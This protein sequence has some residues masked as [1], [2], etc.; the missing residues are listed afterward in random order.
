MGQMKRVFLMCFIWVIYAYACVAQSD[1]DIRAIVSAAGVSGLEDLDEY[2]IE[3]Y[4]ALLS[5]PVRIN[6]E[7]P[8]RLVSSGLLSAFQSASLLDYRERHGDILSLAELSS[9]DGF[10]SDVVDALAP[11]IS[12]DSAGGIL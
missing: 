10:T 5:S 4:W 1:E 11:F 2:D 8:D 7:G 12:M 3:L 6:V 9:V